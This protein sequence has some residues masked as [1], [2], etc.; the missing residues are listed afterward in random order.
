MEYQFHHEKDVLNDYLLQLE[1]RRCFKTIWT[2]IRM[3]N[4]QK[5]LVIEHITKEIYDQRLKDNMNNTEDFQLFIQ[6]LVGF[7][8]LIRYIRDNYR[9]AI[10]GKLNEIY[11]DE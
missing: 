2:T 5:I 6:S 11:L 9:K 7:T 8:K 1:I 10:V 3:I 4:N